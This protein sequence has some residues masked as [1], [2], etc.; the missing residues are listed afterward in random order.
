MNPFLLHAFLR[1]FFGLL[2]VSLVIVLAISEGFYFL[3]HND[4]ERPPQVFEITIPPGTAERVAAGDPG[5]VIPN[6]VFVVGDTL[7]VHNLDSTSHE[8]GPIWLPPDTSG[9][10]ALGEANDFIFNCSFQSTQFLGLTVRE[11]TTWTSRL[12][13]LWYGT[14]PVWMFMLVYSFVLFPLK[15]EE[16]E[17]D[18]KS[19]DKAV[20]QRSATS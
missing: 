8:L 20:L 12:S 10:L 6:M 5:P 1:R 7:T 15:A 11:A 18:V 9:S 2:I 16:T 19:G 3:I 17:D 4:S 14:P 13:A